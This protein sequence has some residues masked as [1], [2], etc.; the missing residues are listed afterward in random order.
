MWHHITSY[1]TVLY[2]ASHILRFPWLSAE[3]SV[4]SAAFNVV[5][6]FTM[7]VLDGPN[8]TCLQAFTH[9]RHSHL[10]F[11]TSAKNIKHTQMYT[12][13]HRTETCQP[14]NHTGSLQLWLLVGNRLQK[15]VSLVK[16]THLVNITIDHNLL[17]KRFGGAI[18]THNKKSYFCFWSTTLTS[19]LAT[20]RKGTVTVENTNSSGI[21]RYCRQYQYLVLE[22]C[23][24]YSVWFAA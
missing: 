1:Q 20:S 9:T 14:T 15:A 22:W 6:K 23:S 10:C 21:K 13:V 19:G 3:L 24:Y 17:T 8:I 4:T 16:L 2:V 11:S 18:R 5:R 12:E 7:L